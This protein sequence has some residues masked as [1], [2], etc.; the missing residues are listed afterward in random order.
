MFQAYFEVFLLIVGG[1]ELMTIEDPLL[2]PHGYQLLPLS[3]SYL[4]GN[5]RDLMFQTYFEVFHLLLVERSL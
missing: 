5:N 1:G 3:T 4:L 2:R